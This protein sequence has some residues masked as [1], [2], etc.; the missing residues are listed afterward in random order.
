MFGHVGSPLLHEMSSGCPLSEGILSLVQFAKIGLDWFGTH[1]IW[2][3]VGPLDG[4]AAELGGSGESEGPALAIANAAL[5]W[6]FQPIL[7]IS[8]QS[9]AFHRPGF[10]NAPGGGAAVTGMKQL[11]H[12]PGF[13]LQLGSPPRFASS[14][15]GTKY[16]FYFFSRS[17]FGTEMGLD[18]T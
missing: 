12:A 11:F 5:F 1:H 4:I 17:S 15:K 7:Q 16:E 2:L 8:L 9:W 10:Q 13:L 6:D 18:V 14:L 3:D